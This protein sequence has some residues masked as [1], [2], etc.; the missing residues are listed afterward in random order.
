MRFYFR[1]PR[2]ELRPLDELNYVPTLYRVDAAMPF[3]LACPYPF[4][5]DPTRKLHNCVRLVEFKRDEVRGG[6]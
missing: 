6:V 1:D 2:W 4:V 5:I 3:R